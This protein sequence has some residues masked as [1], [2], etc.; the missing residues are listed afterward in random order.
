MIN[1]NSDLTDGDSEQLLDNAI[2]A[3]NSE[4]LPPGMGNRVLDEAASWNP[5]DLPAP[6][7]SWAGYLTVAAAAF[8]TTSL[9]W[10]LLWPTLA[11]LPFIA[12][13]PNNGI[14]NT[15][16]VNSTADNSTAFGGL[17]STAAPIAAPIAKVIPKRKSYSGG[18]MGIYRSTCRGV[19]AK[20]SPIIVATGQKVP[21]RLG[22]YV[23]HSQKGS[24]LHVWNWSESNESRVYENI[25]L[26][27]HEEFAVTPDGKQLVWPSGR[28]LDLE[29]QQETKIDLGGEHY[30]GT[31]AVLDRIKRLQFGPRGERLAVQ[32]NDINVVPSD[33]PLR[34]R[35][36]ANRE[37][38]QILDFPAC[39]LKCEIPGGRL[40][41][42]SQNSDDVFSSVLSGEHMEQIVEYDGN[43][44]EVTRKFEPSLKGYAYAIDISPDGK[45]LAVYDGKTGLLIW[46]RE[47][48]ELL[49]RVEETHGNV[50]TRVIKFSPAGKFLAMGLSPSEVVIVEVEQGGITTSLKQGSVDTIQWSKD[51]KKLTVVARQSIGEGMGPAFVYNIHKTVTKWDW[52]KKKII[53]KMDSRPPNQLEVE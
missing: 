44:G 53:K 30:H 29:T 10:I 22:Q 28:V 39:T 3:V 48:G 19:V 2:E 20:N 7:S 43:T 40:L 17:N 36:L 24:T 8:I 23:P 14:N 47:S 11:G 21:L 51:G 18:P 34:K 16:A 33:H 50:S 12:G 37:V 38:T 25:R 45:R 5:L 42:F 52:Q 9:A 35:D 15:Y 32:I 46:N 31:A 27:P 6:S 4:L 13:G 41:A 1:E 49:H 26:W